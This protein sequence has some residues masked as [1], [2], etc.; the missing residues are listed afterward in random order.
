MMLNNYREKLWMRLE[1]WV[2]REAPLA[3]THVAQT[4]QKEVTI[5]PASYYPDRADCKS[6]LTELNLLMQPKKINQLAGLLKQQNSEGVNIGILL[7]HA[8]NEDVLDDYLSF[9]LKLYQQDG[10]SRTLIEIF[11][12]QDNN[13]WTFGMHLAH[14]YSK[15]IV[16]RYL[17]LVEFLFEEDQNEDL[18]PDPIFELMR[19]KGKSPFAMDLKVSLTDIVSN[20]QDGEVIYHLAASGLLP[21]DEYGKLTAQKQKIMDYIL[22]LTERFIRKNALRDALTASHPLG[23]VFSYTT[24]GLVSFTQ[25]LKRE[26]NKLDKEDRDNWKMTF[27]PSAKDSEIDSY[28]IFNENPQP[29]NRLLKLM[30]P[31][32]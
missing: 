6:L 32:K 13:G 1:K 25:I 31:G 8:G 23:K 14:S 17:K 15:R 28:L 16:L 10:N 20:R 3:N 21:E 24:L 30:G 9:L 19:L 4:S 11:S 26:F 27:F 29:A 5:S 7:V 2:M 12:Q 22:S 18:L